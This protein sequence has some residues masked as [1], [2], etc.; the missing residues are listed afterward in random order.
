MAD[1]QM[2]SA[3]HL[4]R[5][6]RALPN[7]MTCLDI[8]PSGPPLLKGLDQ[9]LLIPSACKHLLDRLWST[10]LQL[11][12]AIAGKSPGCCGEEMRTRPGREGWGIF[13]E[14]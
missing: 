14:A 3:A 4:R 7:C 1:Q 6:S 11:S 13:P 8:Q 9:R 5:R 2:V 12:C 10:G